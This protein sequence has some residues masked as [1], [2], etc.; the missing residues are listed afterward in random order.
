MGIFVK[1]LK[2]LN[3]VGPVKKFYDQSSV[4]VY[5]AIVYMSG[6][7]E[8]ADEIIVTLDNAGFDNPYFFSISHI[9]GFWPNRGT[10][11]EDT[12]EVET[13]VI[14]RNLYEDSLKGCQEVAL[15]YVNAYLV[16]LNKLRS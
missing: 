15:K 5:G 7:Q 10:D 9:E 14:I 4:D 1:E 12:A 16:R 13:N 2:E 11:Y 3:W 8:Y 6:N